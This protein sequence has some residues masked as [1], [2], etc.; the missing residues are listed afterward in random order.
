MFDFKKKGSFSKD[1]FLAIFKHSPMYLKDPKAAQA[2][3]DKCF[4]Y[5]KELYGNS[6][7]T[8]REFYDLVNTGG[9]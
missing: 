3:V 1:E 7:I 9:R 6:E 2:L 5:L 4:S 8:P